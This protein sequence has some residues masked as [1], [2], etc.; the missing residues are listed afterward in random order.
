MVQGLVDQLLLVRFLS[1]GVALLRGAVAL[2]SGEVPAASTKHNKD[3]IYI[4][5]IYDKPSLSEPIIAHDGVV[6]H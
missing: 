1:V 2:Q 6:E 5:W 4:T 3:N